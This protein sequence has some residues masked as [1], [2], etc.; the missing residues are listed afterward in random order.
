MFGPSSLTVALTAYAVAAQVPHCLHPTAVQKKLV[1]VEIA[2]AEGHLDYGTAERR[3]LALM[4]EHHTPEDKGRV[5]AMIASIYYRDEREYWSEVVSYCRK[6]L[7]FP[8]DKFEAID[9]YQRWGSALRTRHRAVQ[10]GRIEAWRAEVVMPYLKALRIVL[11]HQTAPGIRRK[12]S[13]P[14]MS[15]YD[16]DPR[17]VEWHRTRSKENR[18]IQGQNALV[19]Y[20]CYTS[21]ACIEL[22]SC[23]PPATGELDRLAIEVLKER[24]VVAEIVQDVEARRRGERGINWDKRCSRP[25]SLPGVQD[26]EVFERDLADFLKR[27]ETK[28]GRKR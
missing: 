23:G 15:Y 11:D 21:G 8:L 4:K 13:L 9:T 7:Q 24:Q 14:I 5:Y 20:R 27:Y 10:G 25:T 18:Q 6:A 16:E 2:C 3:C 19:E 1:L 28:Q 26:K 12:M 17:V 22:Y